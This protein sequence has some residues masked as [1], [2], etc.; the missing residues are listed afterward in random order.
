MPLSMD[1][2]TLGSRVV[3]AAVT[4]GGIREFTVSALGKQAEEGTN[5]ISFLWNGA[6]RFGGFL[7]SDVLHIVFGVLSFSWSL[8][9]GLIVPT[10]GFL[11]NFNLGAPDE[12]EYK[13]IETGIESTLGQLGFVLGDLLGHVVCGVLPGTVIFTFNEG[14]ALHIFETLGE[15]AL[16]DVAGN[17]AG[18]IQQAGQAA[19][20]ALF[21]YAFT[22]I[23]SFF[24]GGSDEDFKN[25]LLERGVWKKED[26]EKAL[27][28][29][30]KPWS[31]AKLFESTVNKIPNKILREMIKQGVQGLIQACVQDGYVIAG[32]VDS[33]I[34]MHKTA[35]KGIFGSE[36]TVV[37]Q[38]SRATSNSKGT[39]IQLANGGTAVIEP[40]STLK[41]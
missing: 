37:V 9:W 6:L 34:A 40:A 28:T 14:L 36:E 10:V 23:R 41:K 26:I 18:L 39:T 13:Q 33:Y 11:W 22:N 12:E 24:R 17:V 1:L 8:L 38:T 25:Q 16:S 5:L 32:G 7:I 15:Q 3:R 4:P 29:R 35:N 27:K 19:G 2:A 21:T 31:F 20:Q 30:N